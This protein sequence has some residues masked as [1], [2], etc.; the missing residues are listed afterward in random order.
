M[1]LA[2]IDI[3]SNSIHIVIYK[4]RKGD[5]G[6]LVRY[7]KTVRL[8]SKEN[9][10]IKNGKVY[11]KDAVV[12][13]VVKMMKDF[14]IIADLF[15][16]DI[17]AI[18]TSAMREATNGKDIV[19]KI[20]KET[21][22]DV[23]IITHEDEARFAY[24][25]AVYSL[26][27]A[28]HDIT[29][30]DIGGGSMQLAR[31]TGGL[32]NASA[33]FPL[34]VVR[35]TELFFENG[36]TEEAVNALRAYLRSHL[37]PIA[38]KFRGSRVIGVSGTFKN[39]A[40][41]TNDLPLK[42][43]QNGLMIRKPALDELV[44]LYPAMAIENDLPSGLNPTRKDTIYAGMLLVQLLCDLLGIDEITVSTF[45]VKAGAVLDMKDKKEA[46]KKK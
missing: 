2:C 34:G 8:A 33:G 7:D 30:V 46:V 4:V 18:A 42:S 45:G 24:I 35:M 29:V 3:G 41:I 17:R 22:I 26:E 23:C 10:I 11:I 13:K 28:R 12:K 19:K 25:G 36:F 27:L 40:R 20:Y 39:I 31:G 16:A 32:F 44:R 21:G 43:S 37:E 38:D 14:K 15:T 6:L 1:N 9:Q 5:I